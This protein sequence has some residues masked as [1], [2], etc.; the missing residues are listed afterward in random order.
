MERASV[1][2]QVR[3]KHMREKEKKAIEDPKEL[4]RELFRLIS[5]N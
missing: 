4:V 1:G 5:T 2:Y 3:G